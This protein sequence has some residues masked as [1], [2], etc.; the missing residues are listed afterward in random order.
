MTVSFV[1]AV[2]TEIENFNKK[3]GRRKELNPVIVENMPPP[4]RKFGR[5]VVCGDREPSGVLY[6]A[7]PRMA[8]ATVRTLLK[9]KPRPQ[10]VDVNVFEQGED[11]IRYLFRIKLPYR[12]S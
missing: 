11:A 10:I 2:K 8:N 3:R 5:I 12:N 7:I 9:F 4:Y 1:D 6:D